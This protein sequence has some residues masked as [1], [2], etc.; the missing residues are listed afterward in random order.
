[1]ACSGHRTA[2]ALA[3]GLVLGLAGAGTAQTITSAQYDGPTNRYPHAVLGDDIEYTTL[4][5]TLSDGRRQSATWPQGMVFEDLAPR[6]ADVTG[7]G[8]P[9]VVVVETSDTA[10]GRLAIWG[11][12]E[13][14][15]THL[16]ATP[17]IGTRFR[18][19]A[20]VAVADLDGDGVTEAAYIDRPHLAKVLRVWRITPQGTDR[21]VLTEV[22]Q[23]G[24]L[25]NHRIGWDFIPGGLRECGNGPEMITADANWTATMATVFDGQSLRTRQIKSSGQ[26]ADLDTALDCR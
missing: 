12:V 2:V 11:L 3:L 15:L 17:H 8:R 4:T 9:E 20:P 22:A 23:T 25:T 7:D 1:M 18:W 21:L 19:L 10:G 13:G 16:G 6:L 5:V 26:P 14:R 24:G